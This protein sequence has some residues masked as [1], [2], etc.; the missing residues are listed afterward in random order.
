[1]KSVTAIKQKIKSGFAAIAV[2]VIFAVPSTGFAQE[3]TKEHI[4]AARATMV[5]T[6][7]TIRLDGIL[8]EVAT[9]VKAGL[10]ANRPDIESEID[11]IVN[12]IAISLAPRRGP[13]ENEVASIYGNRF[14]QEELETIQVF[15][16]SETGIKFLT[17]TP[18]LFREVDQV[19]KVW[20]EGVARD[21]SQAVQEKMKAAG[22][23]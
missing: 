3:L 5:A 20:R 13:L 4:K 21:M 1:M 8:P 12:E 15:F 2:V 17:Q 23:Q 16:A 11:T 19:S 22:L 18:T 10:I 9:F 14:T 7:A 6:G